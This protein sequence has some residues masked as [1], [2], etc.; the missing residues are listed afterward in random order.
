MAK[1]KNNF[2]EHDIQIEYD[3]QTVTSN[4]LEIGPILGQYK[5][6]I[7]KNKVGSEKNDIDN[8]NILII[9][10]Y[11]LIISGIEILKTV[12]NEN[13]IVIQLIK[14]IITPIQLKNSEIGQGSIALG[15]LGTCN[16][17]IQIKRTS[18][19][20]GKQ[21]IEPETGEETTVTIGDA[22][23]CIPLVEQK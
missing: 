6:I 10:L 11:E 9:D 13:K 22:H 7:L 12:E 19:K 2:K 17:E 15:D 14:P 21:S 8:L 4:G 18:P 23:P 20:K 1:L 16:F 3:G 5:P